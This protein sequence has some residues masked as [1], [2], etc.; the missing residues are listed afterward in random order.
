MAKIT[1]AHRL[2]FVA[3]TIRANNQSL[4]LPNVLLDTGSAATIFKTDDLAQLGV[5]VDS[6]DR[7]R[8]TV[9]TGG[10]EV[11]VE[12]QI[13]AVELGDLVISPFLIKLSGGNYGIP[14]D[15]IVGFDFLRTI[16]AVVDLHSL[17]VYR[18][19]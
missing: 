14:M 12:K 2:P 9:G 7:L 16:R 19:S 11:V 5:H 13:T 17:E 6:S 18:G 10:L 1:I 4:Y 8:Y 15:G 3:V